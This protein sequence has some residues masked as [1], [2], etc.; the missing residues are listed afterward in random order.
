MLATTQCGRGEVDN[1]VDVAK[2]LRSKG[3]GGGVFFC[4]DNG[5]AV[6]A[7]DSYFG[8]KRSSLAAA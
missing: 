4:A 7:L 5:D 2:L 6:F 1:G 3:G 8:D